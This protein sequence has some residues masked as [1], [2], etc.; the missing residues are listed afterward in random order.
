MVGFEVT[1][2][3]NDSSPEMLAA[4]R[5]GPMAPPTETELLEYLMQRKPRNRERPPTEHYPLEHV[6][7]FQRRGAAFCW[8]RWTER[9]ALDA[10]GRRRDHRSTTIAGRVGT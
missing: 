6:V 8:L 1:I 10:G 9:P 7:A 4:I 3:A 5:R 2:T